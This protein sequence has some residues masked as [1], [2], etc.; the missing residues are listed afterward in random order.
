[1]VK[2][3]RISLRSLE[4]VIVE[5]LHIFEKVYVIAIQALLNIV[6]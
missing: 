1:M 5:S 2:S 4:T 6:Q 3:E